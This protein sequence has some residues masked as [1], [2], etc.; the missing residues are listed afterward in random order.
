M[1][2]TDMFIYYYPYLC[3]YIGDFYGTEQ[4]YVMPNADSVMIVHTNSQ[5]NKRVLKKGLELKVC[6]V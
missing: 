3:L 1:L 4:S 2:I 6:I 5:G